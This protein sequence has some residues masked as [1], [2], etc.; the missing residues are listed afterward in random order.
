MLD[1]ISEK[2]I[3]KITWLLYFR[4]TSL[5]LLEVPLKKNK[6]RQTNLYLLTN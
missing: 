6:T 4:I 3:K 5:W 2:L 1:V